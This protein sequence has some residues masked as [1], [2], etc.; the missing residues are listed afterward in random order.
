MDWLP[1]PS[2]LI[3]AISQRIHEI[4][5]KIRDALDEYVE[6]LYAE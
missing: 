6:R 4:V 1:F 3:C 5:N 2:M